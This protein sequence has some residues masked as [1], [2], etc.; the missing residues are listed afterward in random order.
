MTE[1]ERLALTKKGWFQLFCGN[2]ECPTR[3]R[4][5]LHDVHEDDIEDG[6][7]WLCR[8]CRKTS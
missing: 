3:Q 5:H 2:P 8:N 7:I 1:R 4:G 6:V